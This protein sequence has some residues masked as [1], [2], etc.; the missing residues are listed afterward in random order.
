MRR[1]MG[2]LILG[3]VALMAAPALAEGKPERGE[4]ERGSVDGE[5]SNRGPRAHQ[6]G[7]S[8]RR[9]DGE[10]TRPD[11]SSKHYSNAKAKHGKHAKHSKHRHDDR[12][13][14]YRGHERGERSREHARHHANRGHGRHDR[15]A[16]HASGP[17][18]GHG[19]SDRAHARGPESRH[20]WSR[21]PR[22]GG[23]GWSRHEGHR[24]GSQRA[25]EARG[26]GKHRH[27]HAGWNREDRPQRSDRERS[28]ERDQEQRRP[29]RHRSYHRA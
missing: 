16:Q 29:E 9:K 19:P 18:R 26:S 10:Q 6:R 25:L 3:V 11:R 17:R 20:D 28:R 13:H 12:R 1:F 21:G 5:R 8:S 15:S 4:R 23:H 27:A 14:A 24:P 2:L 22:S 7:P